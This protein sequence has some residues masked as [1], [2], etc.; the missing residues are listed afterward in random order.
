MIKDLFEYA[1]RNKLRFSSPRGDLSPEQLWDVPLRSRDDFNL[2]TVAKAASRALKE[3]S[4][5]NFVE[6]TKT[7]RH[8][9]LE[10]AMQVV[11]RVIE[12]KLEEEQRAEQRASNKMEKDK[13][14]AILAEKQAGKLSTLSENELKRRIEALGE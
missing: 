5:E 2:N 12:V 14:L 6:A 11:E 3:A 9:K 10:V 8:A 4:D 7:P 13:L 1:V